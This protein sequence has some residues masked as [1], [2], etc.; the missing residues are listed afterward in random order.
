VD[1][2]DFAKATF[3][4]FRR[5]RHSA[6]YFDPDAAPITESDASW[7]IEKAKAAVSRSRA[8]LASRSTPSRFG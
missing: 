5:T 2:P 8:L 7:A 6:Q 1:I 3:E 4:R